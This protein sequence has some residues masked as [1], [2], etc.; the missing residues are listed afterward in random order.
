[1]MRQFSY[2]MAFDR[3]IGWLTEWEQQALRGK[4]VAIAGMGGVGGVHMLTLARFGVGAFSTSDFDRFDIANFNRQIGANMNTIGR[5]KAEV[6]E[7]MARAINP[8]L[9]I[10]RFDAGINESN[11]DAFLEGVDVYVD[12][13]DFFVLGIRRKVF[14]RCAEL[15]IPALCAAPIG[16]G[17][18][19]LAFLPGKMT[20]EQYFR[21]EGR[22]EID[23]YLRFLVGLVPRALHRAYL[24]DPSRLDLASKRGPSTGASCQLCSGVA[25]VA[26]VKLMLGRGGVAAVPYH[27][28]YDPYVGRL[29]ISKLRWGNAGPLQRLKLALGSRQLEKLSRRPARVMTD[30]PPRTP[31]EEIL[32]AARWAPSGDNL[33]PWRFEPLGEASLRIHFASHE[34][35]NIYE[36]RAGEPTLLAVGGLL[37]SLEIAASMWG[38]SMA[39]RYEGIK[40]GP[41]T[42]HSIRVDFQSAGSVC[43]DPLFGQ[44]VLRSVDRRRYRMRSLT[45]AEKQMLEATIGPELVLQW[46][47]GAGH[48]LQLAGLSARAT[49]IRLRAPEAWP[50]HRKMLDF[51]RK[52][53]P[54]GIPAGAVGLNAVTLRIMKWA[55]PRWSRLQL[56]NR[57][58]GSWSVAAELDMLPGLASAAYFSLRLAAPPAE[59]S[60]VEQLLNAGRSIQRFWLVAARLGLGMQPT[61]ATLAFAQYGSTGVAFTADLT[62]RRREARLARRFKAILGRGP[63]EYVFIARIGESRPRLPTSRSTRR[64][65][66]ELQQTGIAS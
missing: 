45:A 34:A 63:E 19:F 44:L 62:V 65:L 60:R 27:H 1:M 4:R 58:G 28:H 5:P 12:G 11:I 42:Q 64:T 22:S 43:R 6:L 55:M 25:A 18:G 51:E 21:L 56:L 47:E 29:V 50:V 46:H 49:D 23:Q 2:D 10:R 24:V 9:D 3:N 53:S 32:H 20:F 35:D 52:H 13:F 33:Q 37:E 16:M 54:I 61:L 41:A 7:E 59:A 48:R 31:L 57:L 14:D 39:W 8:E 40:P 38:R 66:A 26:A 30:T 17:V 15:G 36:Y